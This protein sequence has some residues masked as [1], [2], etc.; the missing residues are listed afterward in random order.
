[1]RLY[2]L[3]EVLTKPYNKDIVIHVHAITWRYTMP[4]CVMLKF[5]RFRLTRI[6]HNVSLIN[7]NVRKCTE[8]QYSAAKV[9]RIFG[10]S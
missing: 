3:A 4:S 7:Q 10:I 9:R 1:M 5:V 2:L 6:G 8:M